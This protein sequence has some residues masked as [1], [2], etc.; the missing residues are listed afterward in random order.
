MGAFSPA[1]VLDAIQG[2]VYSQIRDVWGS[3]GP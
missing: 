3:R 2:V 1:E